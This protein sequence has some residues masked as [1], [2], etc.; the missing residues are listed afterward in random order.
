M[1]SV[2][3]MLDIICTEAVEGNELGGERSDLES[4]LPA[5]EYTLE[6][7]EKRD[8]TLEWVE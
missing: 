8:G 3:R 2:E 5:V 1:I 4:E 7:V 6:L